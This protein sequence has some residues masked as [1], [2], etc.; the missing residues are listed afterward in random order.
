MGLAVYLRDTPPFDQFFWES[1]QFK[2][3]KRE[4]DRRDGWQGLVNWVSLQT[5][6]ELVR[7]AA[8]KVQLMTLHAAKG[9]EFDAV[10]MPACEEGILPFAGMDL[11]TAKITLTPGRGQRFSEERR[12][13]YVG[14]TRARKNLYISR[15]ASR[16][17]YGKT[18]HLPPSR[19]LRELP[20]E[21]LSRSTL[22]ARKVTREKQLG[23]LD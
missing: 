12:L 1:R 20:E 8:E 16:Q 9:L 2:E 17:L 6:L 14:M 23:L 5:E 18:L 19:Y 21:H 4:F 11:L 22:S 13:M 3:L 7:R 10:F 15:A